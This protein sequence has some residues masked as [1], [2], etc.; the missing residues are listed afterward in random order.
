MLDEFI[1]RHVFSTETFAGLNDV[2]DSRR[3]HNERTALAVLLDD[4]NELELPVVNGDRDKPSAD[5][6]LLCLDVVDSP[7]RAGRLRGNNPSGRRS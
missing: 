2:A 1:E 7:L 6:L 5:W 3:A 4:A